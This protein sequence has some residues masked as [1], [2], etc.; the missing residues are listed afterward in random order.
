MWIKLI[1]PKVT[2]RPMDSAWKTHMSPSL[3][4][5]VLAGLTPER[6]RLTIEDENVEKNAALTG[7]CGGQ[8]GGLAAAS[9]R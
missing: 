6:H 8:A 7:R 3:A 2:M 4:L 5:L 9:A 1:S